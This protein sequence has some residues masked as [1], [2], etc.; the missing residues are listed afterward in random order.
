[1]ISPFSLLINTIT[2]FSL[3]IT[4]MARRVQN[5]VRGRGRQ[6]Q[7]HQQ[8]GRVNRRRARRNR[9]P[10][11]ALSLLQQQAGLDRR[12]V[13]V[14]VE[15]SY[16]IPLRE[17]VIEN[18]TPALLEE[19]NLDS[20]DYIDWDAGVLLRMTRAIL[21]YPI[22]G[23]D[24]N[25]RAATLQAIKD[26]LGLRIKNA[27]SLIRALLSDVVIGQA[28]DN[29]EIVVDSLLFDAHWQLVKKIRDKIQSTRFLYSV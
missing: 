1:M 19:F 28:L 6:Q 9:N 20:T 27:H 12:E 7:Q 4:R 17:W 18:F 21:R 25:K 22:A 15:N 23:L 13:M 2:I 8:H 24:D 14:S 11:P 29:L 3:Q 10:P 5:G 26:I 16:T